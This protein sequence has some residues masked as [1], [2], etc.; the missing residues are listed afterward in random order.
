LGYWGTYNIIFLYTIP[1]TDELFCT[2]AH[3][4]TPLTLGYWGTY[5]C[6]YTIIF[7]NATPLTLGY[8]GTYNIIFLYTFTLTDVLFCTFGSWLYTTH[9]GVLRYVHYNIYERYSTHIGVLRYIQYYIPVHFSPH[10]CTLLYIGCTPLTLGHW[11]TYII[12]FM[13]TTPL[14]YALFCT[15]HW[16]YWGIEVRTQ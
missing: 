13:Y 16:L 3:G 5:T 11:G 8:W 12:K 9:I 7:M 4:C 15:L 1:L 10:R 14:T 2:L 6:T